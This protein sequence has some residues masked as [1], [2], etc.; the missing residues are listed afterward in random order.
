MIL[1]FASPGPRFPRE[2]LD[3][4]LYQQFASMCS[5]HKA[6]L[7]AFP[8]GLR[9][10]SVTSSTSLSPCIHRKA[11]RRR[12]PEIPGC[13]VLLT[14]CTCSVASGLSVSAVQLSVDVIRTCLLGSHH[15]GADDLRRHQVVSDG[16]KIIQR[17]NGLMLI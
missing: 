13:S 1:S 7:H 10:H 2:S 3:V 15:V 9:V 16:W 6:T 12:C 5:S 17:A 4:P 11:A 8:P 14:A